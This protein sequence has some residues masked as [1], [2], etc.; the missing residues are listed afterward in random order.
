M[1]RCTPGAHLL[2]VSEPQVDA[3]LVLPRLLHIEV[4]MLK[5]LDELAAGTLHGDDAG[6]HV[7]GHPIGDL[8]IARGQQGLH[9]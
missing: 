6:I 3:K 5:A 9:G 4:D 1:G 8:H 2:A 7:E